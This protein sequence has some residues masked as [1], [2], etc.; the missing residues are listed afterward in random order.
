MKRMKKDARVHCALVLLSLLLVQL[1]MHMNCDNLLLDDWVF[2]D[3]LTRGESIPVFLNTR[4]ETWSSRLLI[5]GTLCA[6]THSIWAWRVLD[7]LAMVL[8]AYALCRL[9]GCAQRPGMLALSAC[10]VTAIPFAVL[11]STGWMAT[12]VN[13]YWPLACTAGALIPLADALWGRKTEPLW[14]LAAVP[15]ALFGANQEQTAA[16]LVGASL[17]FGVALWVRGSRVSAAAALVLGVSVVELA[18]HLLCPGNA[19][20]AQASVAL[21]NLRDYGQFSLIDKLSIGLTSTTALLIYTVNPVLLATG[22]LVA[23]TVTA[24]RRG[25]MANAA[26]V[27]LSLFVLRAYAAGLTGGVS[28][29]SGRNAPFALM[30]G[31]T[32]RLGPEG[33]ARAGGAT[34]LMLFFTVAALGMMALMIYV[35]LGHRPL[36]GACVLV[37]AIGF[38]AR[39]ALSFSPTVVESGER[40]MLPLYG[41]MMLCALLCVRDCEGEGARRWPV[42]LAGAVAALCALCNAAGSFALAA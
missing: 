32:L 21:V 4:W 42:G 41:A 38:A 31:Y 34:L 33:L 39:M 17:V 9:A 1:V 27:M 6:V 26:A 19:V 15:L 7:S 24:R 14:L 3:V 25:P 20:R 30:Q 8:L 5:E 11:R 23:S 37:F 22:A 10:L 18:L 29:M 16:V 36:A 12:S 40:T 35:S 13:Y 28:A 2:E